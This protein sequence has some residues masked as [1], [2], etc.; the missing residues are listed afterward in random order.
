MLARPARH[1]MLLAL[2]LEPAPIWWTSRKGLLSPE[3]RQCHR[4]NLAPIRSRKTLCAA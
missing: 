3:T 1:V 2:A 4:E